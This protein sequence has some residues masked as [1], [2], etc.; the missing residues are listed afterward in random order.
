LHQPLTP[1]DLWT[2]HCRC[3]AVI[4]V[5]QVKLEFSHFLF[6]N[7]GTPLG[8]ILLL[9]NSNVDQTFQ[10]QIIKTFIY[11]VFFFSENWPHM[12]QHRHLYL[13]A[14]KNLKEYCTPEA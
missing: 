12:D 10:T 13:F 9:L 2:K 4:F 14:K 11:H 7:S 1:F 5:T 6:L 3:L 8:R